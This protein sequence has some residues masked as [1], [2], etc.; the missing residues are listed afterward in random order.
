MNYSFNNYKYSNAQVIHIK[1]AFVMH[2]EKKWA[3]KSRPMP[4]AVQ[5]SPNFSRMTVL[6]KSLNFTLKSL[7]VVPCLLSKWIE[8][9]CDCL[10]VWNLLYVKHWSWG[11]FK[12]IILSCR[13]IYRDALIRILQALIQCLKFV[14][15][16]GGNSHLTWPFCNLSHICCIIASTQHKPDFKLWIYKKRQ[17]N[18]Q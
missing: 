12:A 14:L 4:L 17:V 18:S 2:D 11:I 15:E 6:K 3:L 9:D 16:N 5:V 8:L 10:Q 1:K 13:I 7:Y